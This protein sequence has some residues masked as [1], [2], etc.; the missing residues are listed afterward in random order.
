M[1]TFV[2]DVEV[3][4]IQVGVLGLPALDDDKARGI[5]SRVFNPSELGS[6]EVTG[7][8][9]EQLILVGFTEQ[10]FAEMSGDGGFVGHGRYNGIDYRVEIE[11]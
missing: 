2:Q 10:R 4:I 9:D 6:V 8:T 1:S 11:L 3:A 5:L 7:K